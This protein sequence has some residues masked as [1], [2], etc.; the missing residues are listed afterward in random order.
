MNT[1][2]NNEPLGT[3]FFHRPS[4][5]REHLLEVKFSVK[6]PEIHILEDSEALKKYKMGTVE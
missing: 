1:S 6:K 2:F 3:D 5:T 4:N